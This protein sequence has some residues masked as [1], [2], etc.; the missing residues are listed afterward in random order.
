MDESQPDEVVS[1]VTDIV[2]EGDGNT[3]IVLGGN[4]DS[5]TPESGFYD[6]LALTLPQSTLND[7]AN[8][9]LDLIDRDIESRKDRDKMQADGMKKA[10][11]GD[12]APGGAMFEGAS[13]L[14]HPVLID[15]YIQFASNSIKELFPSSG[16]VRSKIEGKPD[17]KKMEKADRKT[18][19]LNWQL[20][21]EV[22]SYRPE[23]ERLLTQLPPGGSQYLKIYWNEDKGTPDVEFV[24]IDDIVLPYEARNFYS[25]QR[26]FHRMTMNDLEYRARVN[27]GLYVDDDFVISGVGRDDETASQR[28]IAKIEG[29]R[30][31]YDNGGSNER[32]IYEGCVYESD[33]ENPEM[34]VQLGDAR[35]VDTASSEK[36]YDIPENRAVPYL[37]TIDEQSKKIL[38]IYRNWNPND[39]RF[40]ELDYLVD[41]TFIPWRGV[42]GLSLPQ[43]MAGLPDAL[44]GALRALMDSALINSMPGG[45]KLKGAPGGAS[46]SI[47]ATQITEI[48]APAADDVRKI[49][50]PIPFN[51]PSPILYQLLEFLTSEAKGIVGIAEESIAENNANMPVGT[52]LA[53]IEQGSKVFSAIHARLHESQRRCLEILHR[54]NKDHMPDGK[55]FYGSGDDDYVTREDFEG[56]LDVRPVS[57]PN[58]FSEAQR[59]GQIQF[60]MQTA[61]QNETA[62]ATN[63]ALAGIFKMRELYARM[64]E[65]AKIPDYQ[66]FLP[67]VESEKPLNPVDENIALV[68]GEPVKAYEGQNHEAHIQVLLD[69][70]QN[71]LLG[72]SPII[73]QKFITGALNHLQDHL[74]VWYGETMKLAAKQEMKLHTDKNIDWDDK[75]ESSV[76]LAKVTELVDKA[77]EV[78]FGKIPQLV[79]AAIQKLQEMAPKP[80]VD[81]MVQVAQSNVQ[82]QQQL[83]TQ[84]IAAQTQKDQ[85]TAQ[86]KAQELQQTAQQKQ[87]DLSLRAHEKR[88]DA[89]VEMKK[90]ELQSQ[91]ELAKTLHDNHT[92]ARVQSEHEVHG[93]IGKLIDSATGGVKNEVK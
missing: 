86:L 8:R 64:F 34:D 60:V 24:P 27:S 33:I 58:I 36:E 90:A 52:T 43:C 75:P 14:T 70:A 39:K 66:D 76:A 40:R 45:I 16:P 59:F 54:L 10:G 13:R 15:G 5:E 91:T 93:H 46:L 68:M 28:Q 9:Y 19:F 88:V 12:P 87:A 71:P 22:P 20:T 3:T 50:M 49:Y 31:D 73:Q 4:E 25:L 23:L 61:Q 56:P 41:W 81:P 47:D 42:F 17:K 1:D 85:T 83:G 74:L 80:P 38:S 62:A 2:D 89:S 79:A 84:R 7:L 69:F 55:I 6:N 67:P 65:M 51:P 32:I 53:L 57:D 29:K 11:L 77:S 92:H 30:N 72:A 48:D 35:E 37:V 82:M 44:T 78:A 18:A 21:Q 26:K 63:P